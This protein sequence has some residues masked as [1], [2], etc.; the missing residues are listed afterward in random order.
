M[1]DGRRLEKKD[2]LQYF[3][4]LLTAL[5]E[6]LHAGAHWPSGPWVVFKNQFLKI[7]NGVWL[8]F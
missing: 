4:N 6:I 8:P 1:A 2:K 5:D 7:E 3:S